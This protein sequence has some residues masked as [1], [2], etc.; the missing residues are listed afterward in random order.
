MSRSCQSATFSSPTSA[1]PRTTRA[2]PQALAG[3]RVALVR[4]RARPFLPG[5][6]GSSTSRTSVRDSS[7]ISVANRSRDDAERDRRQELG[8]SVALDDLL[9][10]A[11]ARARAARRQP[12]RP[13]ARP[14][15][16]PDGPRDLAHARPRP[17]ARAGTV[18]SSANANP[19]SLRPNVVGSACIP[20]V[21]P[22]H[23]VS[24][25]SSARA[26]TAP[27]EQM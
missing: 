15:V 17:R 2:S 25:C 27:K 13:P 26:T 18:R 5:P 16:R 11:R 9:G 1:F 23:T 24:Q 20:W 19:A 10:S 7:R 8:M 21:R 3:R 4:H 22:M 6:S 14:R 12:S